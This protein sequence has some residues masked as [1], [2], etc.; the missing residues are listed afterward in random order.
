MKTRFVNAVPI[1]LVFFAFLLLA[2][3]GGGV[4]GSTS[5]VG[6]SSGGGGTGGGTGGAAPSALSY[7]SPV[8]A[9]V[10]TAITPLSPT[11]TGTV[12]S[13][14]VNPALPTGLSLDTSSGVISGTPTASATKATYTITATNA[15]GSTTFSLSITVSAANPSAPSALSYPGPVTATVGTAITPLSPTV[16]GTV[17]SYSVSPTLPAGLSVNTTSGVISGTPTASAAKATYTITATNGSGSTTFGLSLTVNPANPAAPSALSYPSPMTATVGTAITP[18]SPTVTGTVTSYSVS[19]A[20]PAGLSLNTTSGVI[21]GTPTASAAKT[22]YSITAKNSTGS[23]SFALSLT[24][25]PLPA[26][27]ALSYPSPVNVT[28]GTTITPLSPTVTGNV[29]SYSVNPALPTGLSLDTSSGVISGTP[30][31]G[32]AA[33]TYLITVSN[34]SGS[35]PFGLLLTAGPAAPGL[36][37]SATSLTF[38]NQLVAT[39]SVQQTLAVVNTDTTPFS[40]SGVTI[41]GSAATSFSEVNACSSVAPNSACVIEVTFTPLATGNLSAT[42]NIATGTA[43]SAAVQLFGTAEPIAMSFDNPIILAGQTATLTWFAP[44]ATSCTATGDWSGSQPASGTQIFTPTVPGYTTYTLTCTP[45]GS[46]SVT[47][48]AS[49]PT[50][51]FPVGNGT[52]LEAS[53]T[54]AAPNQTV[55]LQTTLTVPPLPPVPTNPQATL[56]LWP[57]LEP[58]ND[59]ANFSPIGTGVLQPVLTWGYSCA[60]PT[61]TQPARFS[62]WWISA[63]YVNTFGSDPGYMNCF[64]GNLMPVDPGDLLLINMT[65]DTTSG[66][67]TQTVADANTNQSVAFSIDMQRQGQNLSFFDIEEY[68]DATIDTPVTFSDTTITFQS[69]DTT[70]SCSNAQGTNNAYTM[71]PP[72][73]QNSGTQCFI[74]S[75]VVNQ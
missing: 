68:F 4:G 47:L 36:A 29:T 65:L 50:P 74:S 57:G 56:F 53:F 18:L 31:I 54:I 17:T 41:S 14:S 19:P 39:P 5:G 73:L 7:S 61:S 27:S 55:G 37:V 40:V 45:N 30:D 13:Y 72:T 71:T 23:T 21:S 43:G 32:A 44:G 49:G 34:S 46:N 66:I 8:T 67:W 10:G 70:S 16:T 59:S 33:T 24:V 51:N 35:T 60:P 62:S 38:T 20:L 63:Q 58:A 11:V 28:V 1:S 26:P 22:T 48:T 25:N 52:F 2:G 3:C 75:I 69:P 42:L 15:S 6:N 12:T 64:A 9:T